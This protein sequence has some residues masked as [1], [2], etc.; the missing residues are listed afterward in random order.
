MAVRVSRLKLMA[1]VFAPVALSL[2]L[3]V[4]VVAWGDKTNGPRSAR[5]TP[6]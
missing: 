6:E 5:A 1:W 4:G 3:M 2:G